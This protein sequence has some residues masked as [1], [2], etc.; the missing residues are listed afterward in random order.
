VLAYRKVG[1]SFHP[2]QSPGYI[3]VLGPV[4]ADPDPVRFLTAYDNFADRPE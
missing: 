3:A 2:A 4:T 1:L